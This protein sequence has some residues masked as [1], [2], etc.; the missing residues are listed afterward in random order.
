MKQGDLFF[1]SNKIGY[2]SRGET[3]FNPKIFINN[4]HY[5]SQQKY[6]KIL[7]KLDI[8]IKKITHSIFWNPKDVLFNKNRNISSFLFSL[9]KNFGVLNLND[10]QNQLANLS[11]DEKKALLKTGVFFGNVL[12]FHKVLVEKKI[13]KV[14]GL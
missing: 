7:E 6:E 12:A 9:N 3:L 13:K 5:L 1:N 11:S 8:D 10:P 4:N 2:L 14:D